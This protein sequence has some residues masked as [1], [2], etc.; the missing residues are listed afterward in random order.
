MNKHM[1]AA[2]IWLAGSVAILIA[3]ATLLCPYGQCRMPWIDAALLAWMN[4]WRSIELDTFFAA[5]TWLGSLWVLL[6]LAVLIAW[7]QSRRSSL[8]VSAFV[9]V[10]LLLATALGFITKTIVERPRPQF[11][12]G[13]IPL[14]EDW[15][16]PSAHA[17]Q[18]TAFL[19]AVVFMAKDKFVIATAAGA[20]LIIVLVGS[21]RLYLQVHFPTDVIFGVIAAI[22]CIMAA[23]QLTLERGSISVYRHRFRRFWRNDP[24]CPTYSGLENQKVSGAF[25]RLDRTIGKD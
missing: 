2:V 9:P 25:T 21:S 22:G 11:F 8:R 1:L 24:S 23:R 7:T 20:T 3:G 4:D 17:M 14:P 19:L 6:P 10:S 5:M 12:S 16:F 13:P 15:S 18:V